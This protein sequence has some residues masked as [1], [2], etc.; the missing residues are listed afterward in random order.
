MSVA[1]PEVGFHENEATAWRGSPRPP[2]VLNPDRRAEIDERLRASARSL[3]G[4]DHLAADQA[5]VPLGRWDL[6]PVREDALPDAP[7]MLIALP[8]VD[9]E[10]AF[11]PFPHMPSL[12][13]QELS[14]NLELS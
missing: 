10:E 5:P 4:A 13:N 2:S 6:R 3:V 14:R 7:G 9:E 8:P 1:V 11:D 12:T